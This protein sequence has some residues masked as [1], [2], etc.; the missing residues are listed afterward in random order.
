MAH[1]PKPW[2][3]VSESRWSRRVRAELVSCPGIVAFCVAEDFGLEFVIGGSASRERPLVWTGFDDRDQ[4]DD[5]SQGAKLTEAVERA[6]GHGSIGYGLPLRKVLQRMIVNHSLLG[7]FTVCISGVRDWSLP[8]HELRELTRLGSNVWLHFRYMQE[9]SD[10]EPNGV[11]W[12]DA[13]LFLVQPDEAH[14]L[15]PGNA[16]SPIKVETMESADKALP[17]IDLLR[18]HL[19]PQEFD[20]VLLPRPG[21]AALLGRGGD[22]PVEPERFVEALMSRG[23]TIDAFEVLMRSTS[24]FPDAVV[25]AAGREYSERGLFQRL[26]RVLSETPATVRASSEALMRWYFAAATA[27]NQHE[28]IRDEVSRYLMVNEAPELRALFAAAFPGPEFLEEAARALAAARTPTTLRIMAF[29]EILQGSAES[30]VDH[31]QSALRMSERLGDNSMVVATATDLSDYWSREGRY[32]EAVSWSEWA[33]DWYWQSGC[34]DELRLE[35]ARALERFNTLLLSNDVESLGEDDDLDLGR[36]GIPT[37]EALL[38]T[39]A[40]FAFVRGD[41]SFAE[42]VL[43]VALERSQLPQYPGV[44]LDLVHVLRHIGRADE[45]L[46]VASRAH[47]ISRQMLG[48]PKALGSLTM[49]VALLDKDPDEARSY[50]GKALDE[51]YRAHEAPRLAQ[52]A[53]ALG[54]ACTFLGDSDGARSALRRGKRGLVE[55]GAT[56]WLLLGGHYPAVQDLRDRF[57]SEERELEL[58]FFGGRVVLKQGERQD[59]GM[60]QCEVLVAL[61]LSPEGISAEQLGLRVYGEAAVL[62]TI[63]AIVSRLRQSVEV[64]SRPYRV[65]GG[66]KADFLDIEHLIAAGRLR[67]A[68]GYYKGPLLPGSDAPIVVE[69]REHLEELL[70]TSVLSAGDVNCMLRLSD[71]LGDDAELLDAVLD[72]LPPLDPRGSIARAKRAKVEREWKR[73]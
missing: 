66:I 25:N 2:M 22:V 33:V 48:V 16:L 10:S 43:R 49:G 41:F 68:V 65:N 7:P 14:E 51:L 37:S 12:L 39:A 50:L 4:G 55:L 44:A 57:L 67:E 6:V 72:Q 61:A 19:T 73:D 13:E 70:R 45:C 52:C 69:M 31:L 53:I 9:L 27:Q 47:T 63:K 71:A 20:M 15:V 30:A 64:S 54:L 42:R 34:R 35:V 1:S 8:V 62:P 24:D 29:A 56:G 11:C 26:W 36:V 18:A 40:E 58:A 23:R 46:R 38:T 60:R 28:H 21:G 17:I 5:V 59:I 32:R 3:L